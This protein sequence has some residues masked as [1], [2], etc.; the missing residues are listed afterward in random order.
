VGV[1]Q[2]GRSLY[3]CD[4][5]ASVVFRPVQLHGR[6]CALIHEEPL[7]QPHS[8]YARI[9]SDMDTKASYLRSRKTSVLKCEMLRGREQAQEQQ[10]RLCQK[11]K[12]PYR[13]T[14][15]RTQYRM[16][17]TLSD[18]ST[19]LECIDSMPLTRLCRDSQLVEIT[20]IMVTGPLRCVCREQYATGEPALELCSHDLIAS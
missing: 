20:V 8:G 14:K 11:R 10:P 3:T 13:Y 6:V 18:G 15:L 16:C 12:V 1:W 2:V 9:L 17:V 7:V 4:V 5:Y 19:T